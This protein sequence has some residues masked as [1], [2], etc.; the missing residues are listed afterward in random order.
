VKRL[1]IG[2]VTISLAAPVVLAA[3]PAPAPADAPAQPSSNPPVRYDWKGN[4]K[5]ATD[6]L[7]KRDFPTA[8]KLFTEIL[9]SGRL[10]KTWLAPTLYFRGK[11]H[12]SSRQLDKAVTDYEAA[13]AADPKMDV[14]F[15]ELGATLQAKSQHAKAVT[16]F[17]QAIA[18][19]NNNADYYYGRCV[20]YSWLGNFGSAIN[21]CEA[22]T[23][24]RPGSADLLGTLGRLYEDGGQKQR[25]IETY[26]RALAINPNQ[27]EAR[28][29]LKH[30]TK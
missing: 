20:S 7:N 4:H 17:G 10:P 24:L 21:D 11:A 19:K 6:A 1:L 15:Y 13:V 5:K 9:D 27:A 28:D 14:A 12:R 18:L 23:R 3:V 29:G 8:I 22:A 26:K 25:A 16:A 30:L 2:L